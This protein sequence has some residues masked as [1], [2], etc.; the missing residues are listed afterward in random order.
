[1]WRFFGHV[2]VGEVCWVYR[3]PIGEDD[4]K[5]SRMYGLY[6]ELATPEGNLEISWACRSWRGVLG[7]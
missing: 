7:V 4:A 3:K 1:M 2:E 5:E 6:R